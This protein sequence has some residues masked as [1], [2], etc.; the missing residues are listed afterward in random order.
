MT[1]IGPLEPGEGTRAWDAGAPE[2]PPGRRTARIRTALLTRYTRHRRTT[3]ALAAAAALLGAGGYLYATRP[4][5]PPSPSPPPAPYPAQTVDVAYSG[6][7]PNPGGALPRSFSFAVLLSVES[8][9]PV[10][11]TRVTQPYAGLSLVTDPRPPFRTKAGS[12]RKITI[13]MHVTECGKVPM[14]A[15]LPFLDVTLR[16]TRAIQI[17]SFILG[18]RYAQHLSQALK[19][20]CDNKITSSPKPSRRLN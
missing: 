9:P 14:D 12:G 10:T 20:A 18:T 1:G 2:R 6:G 17:Q 15:G 13:T 19:D 4:Q 3:L 8:G 7:R 16:N 5:R 11:V